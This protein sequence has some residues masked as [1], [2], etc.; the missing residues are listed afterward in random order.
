M[1]SIFLYVT[2]V[3]MFAFLRHSGKKL[4]L[5]SKVSLYTFVISY[6]LI[7]YLVFGYEVYLEFQLNKFDLNNDGIYS[8]LEVTASQK[9][10][11]SKVISDTGRTFAPF[12]GFIFSSLI[13]LLSLFI[14][15][16][17]GLVN[18]RPDKVLKQDKS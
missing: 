2:P 15:K 6:S 11:M 1:F 5:A 8:G 10:A 16:L 9:L 3:I 7:I 14:V 12:T 18:K 4:A 13:G 17:L